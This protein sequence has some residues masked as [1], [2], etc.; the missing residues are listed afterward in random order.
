[1]LGLMWKG[2]SA[3]E[4]GQLSILIADDDVSVAR[5][6]RLALA[7]QGWRV[8]LVEDGLEAIDKALAEDYD[9]ILMDQRMPKCSGT[10]AA[11]RIRAQKP[12]QRIAMV[13][14]SPMG[15]GRHRVAGVEGLY[16]LD[17]PFTPSELVAAVKRW[18]KV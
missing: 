12:D 11:Q 9:L 17:K 13:T 1:M 5:V 4:H 7:L 14:G 15:E 2:L 3:M 10:E 18:V 6:M 16:H 8:D